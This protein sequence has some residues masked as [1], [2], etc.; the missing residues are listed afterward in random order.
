[1]KRL[2]AVA[3]W[4]DE[5]VAEDVLVVTADLRHRAVGDS[6]LEAAGRLAERA[7]SVGGPVS[8][9]L[10]SDTLPVTAL[11][12]PSSRSEQCHPSA[13]RSRARVEREPCSPTVRFRWSFYTRVKNH[14]QAADVPRRT[15]HPAASR[16]PPRFRRAGRPAGRPAPVPVP[17]RV[18]P[19]RIRAESARICARVRRWGHPARRPRLTGANSPPS[20]GGARSDADDR[21]AVSDGVLEEVVDQQAQPVGPAVHRLSLFRRAQLDPRL[22]VPSARRTRQPRRRPRRSRAARAAALR[23]RHPERA[24]EVRPEG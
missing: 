15:H 3:L 18:L 11:E 17:S 7:R 4:A 1:M 22:G 16:R 23:R 2:E 24:P 6:D 13:G 8:G 10:R 12:H 5:A 9:R 14:P 20:S 21:A 19:H